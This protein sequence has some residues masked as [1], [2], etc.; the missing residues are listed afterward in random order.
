[1]VTFCAAYSHA[2][3]DHRPPPAPPPP[4]TL[5][6]S[7]MAFD[8]KSIIDCTHTNAQKNAK[9]T[10]STAGRAPFAKTAHFLRFASVL[11]AAYDVIQL[12]LT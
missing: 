10:E 12:W 8:I 7:L 9:H 3:L 1:M 2:H 11:E 4:I 6:H 5:D